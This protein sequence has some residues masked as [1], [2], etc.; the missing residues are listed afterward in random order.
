M[1]LFRVDEQ[2]RFIAA[3]DQEVFAAAEHAVRRAFKRGPSFTNPTK[4]KDAMIAL[5]GSRESEVFCVAHLDSRHNLIC[6]EEMFQGTISGALV[7]PREVVK[8]A[9][10]HNSA[11]LV[12]AHNHP[13]GVCAQSD[14]DERITQRL[15]N[16]CELID[17]RILDHIIV[18]GAEALSFAENGLL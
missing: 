7:H 14:A 18:G 8:A 9:L 2:G 17:V 11:A 15:K 16:A 6:F 10:K 1:Q 4:V 13:S 3:K 5:L 12:L